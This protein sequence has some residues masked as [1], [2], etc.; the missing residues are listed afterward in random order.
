[1]DEDEV[2]SILGES[3]SNY[4]ASARPA[5]PQRGENRAFDRY[6]DETT[7]HYDPSE[8]DFQ[9]LR[10]AAW[11]TWRINPPANFSGNDRADEDDDELARALALSAQ[12]HFSRP[13]SRQPSVTIGDGDED[14]ELR[15]AI[16]LSEEEARAPKRRKRDETPEEERKMLAEAMAA[17]LAESETHSAGPSRPSTQSS[18]STIKDKSTTPA[19]ASAAQQSEPVTAPA[20]RIGGQIIDRAQLERERRE[21]QAARQAAS[22]ASTPIPSIASVNSR[23]QPGPA[24]ISGM[25]S[26]AQSAIHPLQG[27]GPF[28]NDAAGEYYP[29]GELR[30]VALKIGEPSTERTFSPKEV[31][32]KHSQISLIIMSS[33]VIDDMWIMEK[34][35]LPPPEDVPTIIVRPHPRD[36]QDYNGKIQAHPNGEMWAYPKMTSTFGSAHMK[37]YWILY[38]TGRLRTVFVQDFLPLP[39]I[40]P[41]RADNRTHDFP[42]QFAHLFNHTRIDTALRNMLRLHPNASHIKFRPDDNFADMG[43]F[44]WSKVKVRLVLSIPQTLTGHDEI[45]KYGMGRL[46]HVLNEE[47]WVPGNDEKLDV[48]YQNSSLGNYKIDWLDKFHAMILGKTSQ[49]LMNRPKP[50]ELPDIRVLYPTL[51]NVEQSILGKEGGGTM[52]CKKA[53]NNT[54]RHLFRD[55]RSKR[56]G[57]LMH[58]KMLIAIFEPKENRL[59]VEKSASTPKKSV[60]RKVDELKDDVGGWV[61]VGS[62]NFSS[63]AWGNI[64]VKKNPPTESIN[65]YEIGIVFPLDRSNARAAADRI[66]PYKRPALRYT[67]GDVPWCEILL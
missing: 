29:D 32:G 1:M 26:I 58:S 37:Y 66:A 27:S 25:S 13:T 47:G 8:V 67:A 48:E 28:P 63:A 46:S 19:P 64:N 7:A 18:T 42:L 53:F 50:K 20:L 54:T 62:H 45:A 24:R 4:A 38:K 51:A 40:R 60:K 21:R 35:I 41:L 49:E 36:K 14:D 22:G 6:F 12:E 59:G 61:Y 44:D 34:E 57:V 39:T 11:A 16:A 3:S 52:F 2:A 56:G 55:A 43:K 33:Y 30:H 23:P 31:V 5:V 10:R 65:N 15:R 9:E 17:S